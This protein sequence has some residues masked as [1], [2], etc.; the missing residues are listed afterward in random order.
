MNIAVG[1]A[2]MLGGLYIA[3]MGKR[4]SN[5]E[6]FQSANIRGKKERLRLENKCIEKCSYSHKR[7]GLNYEWLEPKFGEVLKIEFE[8]PPG[9]GKWNPYTD[10]IWDIHCKV[11]DHSPDNLV[12]AHVKAFVNPKT[13]FA[14]LKFMFKKLGKIYSMEPTRE[15]YEL[16]EEYFRKNGLCQE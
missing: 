12:D 8:E 1:V 7:S 13:R 5:G 11:V 16:E 3:S 6:K 4:K 15:F 2:M 9:S 10:R 14:R